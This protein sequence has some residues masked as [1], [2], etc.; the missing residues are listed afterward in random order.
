MLRSEPT[1]EEAEQQSLLDAWVDAKSKGPNAPE[2]DIEE[3][4][5]KILKQQ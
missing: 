1:E 3:E 5:G 2:E 4:E